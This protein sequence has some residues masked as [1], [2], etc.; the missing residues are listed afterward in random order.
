MVKQTGWHRMGR[1]DMKKTKICPTCG[2]KKS[3]RS[4]YKNRLQCKSCLS[5]QQIKNNK[6]AFVRGLTRHVL[7]KI[8]S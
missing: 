8:E 4:Y 1:E 7:L 5:R 3:T 6:E 2:E